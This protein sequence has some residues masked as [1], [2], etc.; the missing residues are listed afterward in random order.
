MESGVFAISPDALV[1]LIIFLLYVPVVVISY[2]RLIPRLSP[3]SKR[4]ATVMLAAQVLVI[5]ASLE[6][7]PTFGIEQRFWSLNFENNISTTLASTQL[8]LVGAVALIT[9]WLA[10]TRP[11]LYRLYL[12]GI[13]LV[14]LYLAWEEYNEMRRLMFVGQWEIYYIALGSAVF[15]A[16][17]AVA[18][19]SPRPSW[20]WHICLLAGLAVSSAGAFGVE[21]LRYEGICRSLGFFSG[22][23]CQT[24]HIEES[25]EFLGIWITLL[26]VLGQFSD[27]APRPRPRVRRI[28]YLFPM[29]LF[30][31]LLLPTS[32]LQ[33][34]R[35]LDLLHHTLSTLSLRLEYRFLAQPLALWSLSRMWGCEAIEPTAEEGRISHTTAFCFTSPVGTVTAGL[36]YSVH[37]VD[38]VTGES[39]ASL[40]RSLPVVGS[41]G[42][43]I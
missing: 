19:R 5:V 28:L 25:L 30:I 43:L 23:G 14:F 6:I 9:A 34:N 8:A 7:Q 39:I 37:L 4:L 1:R 26:A 20:I 2:R 35:Q 29:F 21:E 32:Y 36:G 16:T 27:A 40:G 42:G 3:T 22:R 13:A 15:A 12:L 31:H 41:G 18:A 33:L 17:L 11:S 38:Q 10:R 24:Y